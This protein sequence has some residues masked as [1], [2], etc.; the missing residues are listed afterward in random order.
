MVGR[1]IQPGPLFISLVAMRVA[2]L[3]VMV[4]PVLPGMGVQM[5][6]RPCRMPLR[7]GHSRPR[8]R[9]PR[10]HAQTG[11][12]QTDQERGDKTVH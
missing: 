10:T 12:L 9:M 3:T 7:F 1:G 2:P 8:M 5:N 4:M 6:V 11:E